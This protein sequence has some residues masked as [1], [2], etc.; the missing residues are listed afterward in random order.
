[1]LNC[2]IKK[3]VNFIL[4]N[5]PKSYFKTVWTTNHYNVDH[6]QGIVYLKLYYFT[7]V[8]PCIITVT[9][10]YKVSFATIACLRSSTEGISRDLKFQ[11][12]HS[13]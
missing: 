1:M 11:V 12:Y 3:T 13:L 6:A 2:E 5:S 7:K 8:S 10:H 9:D 4:P